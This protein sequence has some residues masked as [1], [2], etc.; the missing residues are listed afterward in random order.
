M[1]AVDPHRAELPV[2]P[3]RG[4]LDDLIAGAVAGDL[5]R[6]ALPPFLRRQRWF[7]AKAR[8]MQAVS[9]IER[10]RLPIEVRP[11]F[12]C[13]VRVQYESGEPDEYLLPLAVAAG[14][15][16]ARLL[17]FS[18]GDVLARVANEDAL[19]YETGGDV[20]TASA[21][22]AVI[23]QRATIEGAG[24]SIAGV[25]VD[26]GL[27]VEL[28]P[29]LTIQRGRADQSNTAFFYG[30]RLLLKLFRRLE[31]GPNPEFEIGSRLT[32]Q[33]FRAI[34]RVAGGLAFDRPEHGRTAIGVLQQLVANRG[35]AWDFYL[36]E[37]GAI[38]AAPDDLRRQEASLDAARQLGVR[39]GEMHVALAGIA[40]EAFTPEPLDAARLASLLDGMAGRA[41]AVL[42]LLRERV[43]TLP[44][45]SARQ[46]DLVLTGG[47][48]LVRR[49]SARPHEESFGELIRV[50]GDYH[51]GQVL[52]RRDEDDFVI[53]DFEGEPARPL[54]ERR[55]RQSPLKDL[56]GMLRSFAY[57]GQMVLVPTGEAD[58]DRVSRLE[59]VIADWTRQASDRLLEGYREATTGAAFL[60]GSPDTFRWLLDRSM[61]DKA[62]YELAYEL[63]SRPDWT[64]IPLSYLA[65]EAR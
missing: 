49:F 10:L 9:F 43:D 11:T 55:A 42:A 62:F 3:L 36:Q 7:G 5:E 14:A 1:P 48:A 58:A 41:S 57:A 45:Q 60:P 16:A 18:P 12:L 25:V 39:T 38:V 19:I 47:E 13:I 26:P 35:S 65:G 4:S 52:R 23:Q 28:D 54:A 32:R 51:L 40:E 63:N 33:G 46:A 31:P 24:G 64:R 15:D 6:D 2:V 37:L 50:H 17:E 20:D 61:L 27:L 44:P 22:L 59:Q 29:T 8:P 21:L 56:A 34:P 53:L 30:D